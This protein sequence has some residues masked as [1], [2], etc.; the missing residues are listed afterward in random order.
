MNETE[1]S[2]HF[3]Y[4]TVPTDQKTDKV[5]HVFESV[6]AK[7][8]LMNDLMS[9][10]IHRWWK[11]FAITQCRLRTGQRILDLAGG[12]GDLAKRISP[13]VG[14]EGEV[15]IA[16]INAAMLNVGRRRLLDQ[17]IFRNIQFIQADAEKLPFPNNFFDRIVI[18]FGL[19][20][21]TNQLA[22]LQSMHRV[23]KPGG[24]VVILEFSKPTLAPLKAVYD[25]YSF[26]L[27]PR[28]GKLVAKDEESY[29]Y[30]VESIRMHPDQEALLSKMTDARFED[31]DYH[32]LSGGIVAV[33]RGYKF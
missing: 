30:L 16:D 19:R 8:D 29:R 13:L 11:A 18:G 10:G 3:G 24:F 2:T 15:V 31:C 26:Q 6:A 33:H 22:A 32:N 1:K 14:D 9:L 23:I 25:A 27:L 7:Y 21:V 12:T 28:L 17:G 4:Q 5:K 20:N